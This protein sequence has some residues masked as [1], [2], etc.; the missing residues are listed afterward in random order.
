MITTK[1]LSFSRD[2][3]TIYDGGSNTSP[4][5]GMYCGDSIP[6]S[7]A[8]SN[9]EV[10]IN[11]H[12][13]QG[14]SF[15]ITYGGFKMEYNPTGKQITSIQNNTEYHIIMIPIIKKLIFYLWLIASLSHWLFYLVLILHTSIFILSSR[16]WKCCI[17]RQWFL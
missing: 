4:R 10:L 11:F 6:P 7:H 16:L 15:S 17:V 2:S 8:S 5:M 14:N 3:L 12:S 9:N 1:K 13:D